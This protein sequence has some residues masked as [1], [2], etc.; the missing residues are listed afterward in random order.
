MHFRFC[1]RDYIKLE[2]HVDQWLA[3]ANTKYQ[4]YR[5]YIFALHYKHPQH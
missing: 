5:S 3:F 2:N 1:L 4:E